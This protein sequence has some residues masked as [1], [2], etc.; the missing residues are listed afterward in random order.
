MNVGRTLYPSNFPEYRIDF[1][2]LVIL[3]LL[4]YRLTLRDLS[5]MVLERGFH[6]GHEA[7][8]EREERFKGWFPH[9]TG[10]SLGCRVYHH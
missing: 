5:G 4:H 10:R 8:R 2:F 7:A 9:G 1:V 3:R 6:C